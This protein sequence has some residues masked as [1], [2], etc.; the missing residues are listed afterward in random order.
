MQSRNYFM[1]MLKRDS[2]PFHCSSHVSTMG[3]NIIVLW[4]GFFML[5]CDTHVVNMS[6]KVTRFFP[7]LFDSTAD[8][9]AI[10]KKKKKKKG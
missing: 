2:I 10:F 4:G 3:I 1:E 5:K 6:Y 7:F 8:M 9:F